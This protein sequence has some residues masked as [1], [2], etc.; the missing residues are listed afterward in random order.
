MSPE[1]ARQ[2]LRRAAPYAELVA[3]IEAGTGPLNRARVQAIR[4]TDC[5]ISKLERRREV[6]ENG[7]R[8]GY[9]AVMTVFQGS[10]SR[11]R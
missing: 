10:G 1:L 11:P 6:L 2:Y 8:R 9:D 4:V 5:H 3:R 7:A